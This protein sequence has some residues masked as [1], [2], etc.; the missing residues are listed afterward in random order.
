MGE[1]SVD[2]LSE[3]DDLEQLYAE[4]ATEEVEADMRSYL[5]GDGSM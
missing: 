3:G 4:V 2:A 5:E 1:S